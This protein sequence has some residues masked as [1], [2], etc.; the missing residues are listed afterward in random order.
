MQNR[1]WKTTGK[2]ETPSPSFSPPLLANILR[3]MY[4]A[5]V[6]RRKKER[7]GSVQTSIPCS[8]YHIS[9]KPYQLRYHCTNT[10]QNKIITVQISTSKIKSYEFAGLPRDRASAR[11]LILHEFLQLPF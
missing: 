5:R 4:L 11:M 9:I 3:T 2:A 8:L 10:K 6:Y 7:I 1:K